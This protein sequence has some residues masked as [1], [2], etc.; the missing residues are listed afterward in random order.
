MRV[1]GVRC[2]ELVALTVFEEK[3]FFDAK[4]NNTIRKKV[5]N[6]MRFSSIS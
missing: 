5:N 6:E 4:K 1:V 3:K 2:N